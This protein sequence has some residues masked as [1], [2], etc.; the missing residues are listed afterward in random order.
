MGGIDLSGRELLELL[1]VLCRSTG[2]A[3]YKLGMV[4][5]TDKSSATHRF[6]WSI[7]RLFR[8]LSRIVHLT[9]NLAVRVE[10]SLNF[11]LMV[12]YV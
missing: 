8:S 10:I 11:Y 7:A 5:L 4:S 3:V 9:L 1:M 2:S 6:A 12:V